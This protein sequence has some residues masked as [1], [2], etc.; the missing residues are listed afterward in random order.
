MACRAPPARA[1][2]GLAALLAVVLMASLGA[3]APRDPPPAGGVRFAALD[4][5]LIRP[6]DPPGS[7]PDRDLGTAEVTRLW[8]ADRRALGLCARRQAG[9]VRIIEIERAGL[10][11]AGKDPQP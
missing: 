7:L 5:E 3:C 4:P 6:C 9:L 11:P 2:S 8:T 1:G 10:G